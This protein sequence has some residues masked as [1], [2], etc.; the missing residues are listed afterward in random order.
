MSDPPVRTLLLQ[1]TRSCYRV[2]NWNPVD[3][4]PS[5]QTAAVKVALWRG[6]RWSGWKWLET[7]TE[8]RTETPLIG[9]RLDKLQQWRERDEV[10]RKVESYRV[11]N[12][13]PARGNRLD[14]LQQGNLRDSKQPR[15]WK[16]DPWKRSCR[17]IF[18]EA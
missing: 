3:R 2:E 13:N 10:V 5:R 7:A 15:F 12:W 17:S 9:N 14:K 18:I 6:R 1:R 16:S 4:E 8:W 11:E